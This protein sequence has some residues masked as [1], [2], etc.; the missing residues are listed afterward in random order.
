[1]ESRKAFKTKTASAR[2]DYKWSTRTSDIRK[3]VDLMKF[4][5]TVSGSDRKSEGVNL[6]RIKGVLFVIAT[7]LSFFMLGYLVASMP[8]SIWAKILIFSLL[9]FFGFIISCFVSALLY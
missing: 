4:R 5:R 2:K 8:L 6:R 7:V 1:M 3:R 9:S